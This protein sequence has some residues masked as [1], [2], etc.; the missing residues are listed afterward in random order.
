[1]RHF[2]LSLSEFDFK[3]LKCLGEGNIIGSAALVLLRGS[4]FIVTSGVT[5]TKK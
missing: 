1:M 2:V 3:V 5:L 4:V